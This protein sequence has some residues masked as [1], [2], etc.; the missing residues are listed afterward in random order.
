MTLYIHPD[1]NTNRYYVCIFMHVL[2][3]QVQGEILGS[4]S[5]FP[6]FFSWPV[7][8][9][10]GEIFGRARLPQ[11][12][13]CTLLRTGPRCSAELDVSSNGSGGDTGHARSPVPTDRCL[14]I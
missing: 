10:D 13:P 14:F 2:R 6:E 1:I 8:L 3:D 5:L 4:M 11:V 7:D 12:G 9:A